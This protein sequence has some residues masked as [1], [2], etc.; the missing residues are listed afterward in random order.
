M[1]Y[2]LTKSTYYSILNVWYTTEGSVMLM[3]IKEQYEYNEAYQKEHIKRVVVKL[4][5]KTDMDIIQH[6]QQ[7]N[8]AGERTQTYIK[9]LIREDM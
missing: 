6:L 7:V 1:A 2:Q 3:G 8:D 9:R 5:D 4:N